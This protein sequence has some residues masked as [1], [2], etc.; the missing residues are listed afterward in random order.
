MLCKRG[1]GENEVVISG[2]EDFAVSVW[3]PGLHRPWMNLHA[4]LIEAHLLGQLKERLSRHKMWWLILL[5]VAEGGFKV[6]TSPGGGFGGPEMW[7]AETLGW[8]REAANAGLTND[9]GSDWHR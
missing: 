8:K 1:K 2:V 6:R 5:N 4:L 7:Q 9:K 3:N